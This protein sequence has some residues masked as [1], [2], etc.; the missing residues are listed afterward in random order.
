MKLS[1]SNMRY[2]QPTLP[3]GHVDEADRLKANE[4]EMFTV[5]SE[6]KKIFIS[7]AIQADG[8]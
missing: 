7:K 3:E 6:Q 2:G 4:N 1:L 8:I 5:T